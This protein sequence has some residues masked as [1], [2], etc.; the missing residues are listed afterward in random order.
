M[1][2]HRSWI[3]EWAELDHIVGRRQSG[4][5]KSFLTQSTDLF[6]VPYGRATEAHPRRG[7]IVGSTN[8]TTGFLDDTT[9]N[10]RFWV[11]PVTCNAARPIDT[12]SLALERDSIWA[13]AVAAYRA[14]ERSWLPSEL[15]QQVTDENESYQLAN[16]WQPA[17]EAWLAQRMPGEVITSESILLHAIEKPL[18]RQTR[19][20]Q[21]AV[22]D[23]LR[24]LGYQQQRSR[25]NG[26]R[27]RRWLLPP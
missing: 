9:G 6:R 2:L 12:G 10:R 23:I 24:S 21:M 16:P 4:I 25:A 11:I 5:I 17:I 19:Q 14:G 8:R 1:K 7:I 15:D 3:M 13:A 22:A 18:E 26:Q 27:V 20:D